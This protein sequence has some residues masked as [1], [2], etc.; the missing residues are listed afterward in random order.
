MPL[1]MVRGADRLR[2][3]LILSED[4]LVLWFTR[5][6]VGKLAICPQDEITKLY[7]VKRILYSGLWIPESNREQK[8]FTYSSEYSTYNPEFLFNLVWQCLHHRTPYLKLSPRVGQL[9]TPLFK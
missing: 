8:L 6:G 3:E 2:L 5:C 4:K 7:N 1:Q 9:A